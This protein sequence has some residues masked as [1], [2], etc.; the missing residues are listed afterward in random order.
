MSTSSKNEKKSYA[1]WERS[2]SKAQLDRLYKTVEEK[3]K[4]YPSDNIFNIELNDI[5]EEV[6]SEGEY[7]QS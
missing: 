3:I 7:E 6:L 1:E 4:S 5:I 2:K